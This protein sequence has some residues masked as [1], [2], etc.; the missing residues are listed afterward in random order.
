MAD[1]GHHSKKMKRD[2]MAWFV[3]VGVLANQAGDIPRDALAGQRR[4]GGEQLVEFLRKRGGPAEQLHQSVVSH[5]R[6][7]SAFE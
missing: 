4:I 7:C 1:L 6:H 5:Q 2:G 3:T